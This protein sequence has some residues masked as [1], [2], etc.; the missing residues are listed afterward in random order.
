MPSHPTDGNTIQKQPPKGGCFVK[1]NEFSLRQPE[2]SRLR[3]RLPTDCPF[4]FPFPVQR[5]F[6][7]AQPITAE[8]HRQR[9]I[10]RY[11]RCRQTIAAAHRIF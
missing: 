8:Q 7:F 3:D 2:H 1:N 6:N 11:I 4:R 5:Q 10:F 9:R